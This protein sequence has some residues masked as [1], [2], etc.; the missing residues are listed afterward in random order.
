MSIAITKTLESKTKVDATQGSVV[1][2]HEITLSVKKK[3]IVVTISIPKKMLLSHSQ[4]LGR[5]TKVK[6][7]FNAMN[8]KTR[9]VNVS[10][11]SE[12]RDISVFKATKNVLDR[13]ELFRFPGEGTALE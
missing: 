13:L 12:A 2:D 10:I 3:V 6:N 7:Q 1:L 9:F 11:V 4:I 5:H 8:R